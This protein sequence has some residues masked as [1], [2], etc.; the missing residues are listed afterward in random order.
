MGEL[1]YT[2]HSYGDNVRQ[3]IG[4][5]ELPSTAQRSSGYWLM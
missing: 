1:T 2:V 4:I 3:R 5:W